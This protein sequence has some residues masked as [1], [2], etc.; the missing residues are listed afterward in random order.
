MSAEEIRERA[1][2]LE[3]RAKVVRSRL[4]RAVDALDERRHQVQH[5]TKQAKTMA[6]PAMRGAAVVLALFGVSAVCFSL[7]IRRRRV[8]TMADRTA[9][10]IRRLELAPRPSFARRVGEKLAVTFVSALA[11]DLAHRAMKNFIDG[12]LPDG[13]LALAPALEAHHLELETT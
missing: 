8:P 2:R 1:E 5:L 10:F 3:R 9:E 12:R 6:L 13:R 11:T 7:A 4:F